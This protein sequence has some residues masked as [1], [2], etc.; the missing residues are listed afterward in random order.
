M[1]G[2]AEG[3]IRDTL[4]ERSQVALLN[5]DLAVERARASEAET[6][7]EQAA[8]ALAAVES[9]RDALQ[10][11]LSDLKQQLWAAQEQNMSQ[12]APFCGVAR[13]ECATADLVRRVHAGKPNCVN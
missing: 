9:V 6:A 5:A 3:L 2:Q 1:R 10:A 11:E 7:R 12:C 4:V 13:G 8:Q